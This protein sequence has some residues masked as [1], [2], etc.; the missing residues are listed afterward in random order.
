[1]ETLAA[2]ALVGN[3]IQFIDFGTKLLS[4]C[5]QPSRPLVVPL[6]DNNSIGTIAANLEC[7]AKKVRDRPCI[8]GSGSLEA[9]CISC[10]TVA[11]DLTGALSS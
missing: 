1:M 10:E 5:V 3:V 9:I 2:I 6:K 4:N 8:D 7:L 11:R